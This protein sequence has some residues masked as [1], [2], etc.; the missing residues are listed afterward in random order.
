MEKIVCLCMAKPCCFVCLI[1]FFKLCC[2]LNKL[3][4]LCDRRGFFTGVEVLD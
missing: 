3:F 1:G 4:F 2:E